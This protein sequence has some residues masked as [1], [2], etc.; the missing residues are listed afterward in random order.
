MAMIWKIPRLT[1]EK[2]QQRMTIC[3][4]QQQQQQEQ[5]HEQWK[6]MFQPIQQHISNKNKTMV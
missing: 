2:Q 6:T 3:L 4:G 5:P 1:I